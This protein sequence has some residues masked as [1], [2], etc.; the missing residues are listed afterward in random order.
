MTATA[1]AQKPAF[2]RATFS[3]PVFTPAFFAPYQAAIETAFLMLLDARGRMDGPCEVRA[4]T[5]RLKSPASIRDKLIK[6]NLPVSA[7]CAHA[8]LHDVSGLRVVLD[9]TQS[10]YRF[11]KLLRQTEI[12]EY[13]MEHDYIAVPKKSGYRSLHLIMRVPVYIG[14][15]AYMIPVEIQLRTAPMDVWASIEHELIYKPRVN[16]SYAFA[17]P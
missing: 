1:C 8:A 3:D 7:A 2:C 10:V 17:R 16:P 12:A 4:M 6:K 5:F 9:S 13:D 11:A 14:A 15:Q